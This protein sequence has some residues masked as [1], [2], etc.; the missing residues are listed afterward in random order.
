MGGLSAC[1]SISSY[2]PCYACVQ[3]KKKERQKGGP[4]SLVLGKGGALM[5]SY[6]ETAA[7]G[8]GA[9]SG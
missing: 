8:P 7:A 2:V 6:M 4:V 3:D 1:L 5:R 9:E